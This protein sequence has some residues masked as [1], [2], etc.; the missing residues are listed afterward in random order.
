MALN[1]YVYDPNGTSNDALFNLV[2]GGFAFV[3]GKVAHTGYTHIHFWVNAPMRAMR[4]MP[5]V[6]RTIRECNYCS[7]EIIRGLNAD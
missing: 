4:F 6:L 2:Q 3:A 1:D 7:E 5:R